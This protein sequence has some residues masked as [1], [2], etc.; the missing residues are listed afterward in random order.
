MKSLKLLTA[1]L[2]LTVCTSTLFAHGHDKFAKVQM[3]II[4]VNMGIYMLMGAGGNIGV[5]MGDDGI[6]MVD[7]QFA[8]LTDKIKSAVKEISDKPIKYVFNTHWHYDHTGG[9]ENL[10]KDGVILVSHDNVRQRL[11]NGGVIKAFG[12]K[13]EPSPLVA[14]PDITFNDRMTF[15]INNETVEIIHKPNAHTDGD[16][17]LYFKNANVVHTGDIYFNGFYPF[18]DGSSGG[19]IDGIIASVTDILKKINE[20]TKIIPGHGKLSNKKELT[21]YRDTLIILRDRM[22]NLI[23]QGKT[24]EEVVAMMPNKDID[25]KLGGGFLSPENF[26]KILYDV[27]KNH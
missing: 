15:H 8:P 11:Q 21:E 20:N 17:V 9:N 24:L 26:L 18:I 27:V 22:K 19:S 5:S 7:D 3:K 10:G 13:I 14:L 25:K 23:N 1:G 6:L 12:K 4:P 16:A 2:L